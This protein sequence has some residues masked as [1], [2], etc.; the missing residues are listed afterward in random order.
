MAEGNRTTTPDKAGW[1][2][3]LVLV[4]A[5]TAL[6]GLAAAVMVQVIQAE[7][8]PAGEDAAASRSGAAQPAGRQDPPVAKITNGKHAY[9]INESELARECIQR[10]GQDVLDNLINRS[11]IQLACEERNVMVTDQEIEDEIV[12]VAKQFKIPVETWLQML[13]AERNITPLQYRRDVIWPMLALR[14]LTGE[15]IEISKEELDQAFVR[16][17]GPRVKARM[18][19]SDNQ[20]RATEVWE[21]ARREPEE[22]GRLAR[23]HSIDPNSAPLDGQIHPI[24]MYSAEEN[25]WKAAFQLKEGEISGIIQ[26]GAL[27]HTRYVILKCEG[28]TEQFVE[29]EQVQ[30]QLY[31]DL[32]KEKVQIQAAKVFESLKE[33]TR[34]DNYLTNT[35]TGGERIRPVSGAARPGAKR[36]VQSAAG[37]GSR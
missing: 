8:A 22:F 23:E 21:K 31:E 37:A 15:K 12:R 6:I 19:M 29:R 24:P 25:L 35:S 26:V 5:G 2:P 28:R 13:Q 10:V 1:K 3:K 36:Q 11:I 32:Q 16:N 33:E 4:A 27:P 20:R 30:E 17:Y 7:T 14:K 18:I 34:V 9:L